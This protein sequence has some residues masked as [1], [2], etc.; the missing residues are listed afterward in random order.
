MLK[1]VED[2]KSKLDVVDSIKDT[3]DLNTAKI[4]TVDK[5]FHQ[6]KNKQEEG[7]TSERS[8]PHKVRE[9]S[10]E[11]LKCDKCHFGGMNQ[12]DL[13]R[14]KEVKHVA[15]M[16]HKTEDQNK[17]NLNLML[18]TE[19]EAQLRCDRCKFRTTDKVHFKRHTETFVHKSK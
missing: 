15:L 8:V 5:V 17:T 6:L 18:E 4:V 11:S 9:N 16:K 12:N 2:M 10:N 1:K 3:V 7:K 14:H 19:A 13:K